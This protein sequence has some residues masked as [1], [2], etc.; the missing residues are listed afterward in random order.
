MVNEF[1][2][3]DVHFESAQFPTGEAVLDLYEIS[4]VNQTT[5][6]FI[7]LGYGLFIHFL[8]FVVLHL[9]FV[10]HKRNQVTIEDH[11]RNVSKEISA[12]RLHSC[13]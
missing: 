12:D 11:Y 10:R 3:D 9:K 1:G 5:D 2:G 6:M 8:S 13:V 4:N 7:L